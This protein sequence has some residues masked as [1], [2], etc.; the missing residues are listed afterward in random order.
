MQPTTGKR[1]KLLLKPRQLLPLPSI[2]RHEMVHADKRRAKEQNYSA[3]AII[4]TRSASAAP[5]ARILPNKDVG[6][7]RRRHQRKHQDRVTGLGDS[8]AWLIQN[9]PAA[10]I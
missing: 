3:L 4:S 7:V 6:F 9:S 2:E 8:M 10:I 5:A 1:Q